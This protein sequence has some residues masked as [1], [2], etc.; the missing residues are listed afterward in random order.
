MGSMQGSSANSTRHLSTGRSAGNWAAFIIGLPLGIGILTFLQYGPVDDS[1]KRYVSHEVEWVEVVMFTCALGALLS[2]LARQPLERRAFR[3]QILP[4]WDGP[5]VPV[6]EATPLFAGLSRLPLYLQKTMV[7][8]RVRAV[9]EFLCRRGSA[10]ELDDQLRAVADNDAMAQEN[11]YS[12]IRFITW[13]IPILGFLG[14]V[15]GITKS[16]S[17]IDPDKLEHDLSSVTDGL[18]FAFD[19]TALALG[20]TMITMFCTFLV[21]RTEQGTLEAVDRYTEQHLAHRFQRIPADSGPFVEIVRQNAQILVQATE[22]LVRR[23]AELWA[24]TVEEAD[25]RRAESDKVQQGILTKGLEAALENTLQHHQKRL[26]ALEKQAEA[27]GAGMLDKLAGV[28]QAVH[29][30][31]A[32]MSR[33]A[34]S[35]AMHAETLARLQ[36]SEHHLLQLQETLNRN[37]NL[38]AGAGSFEQ[39]VHSLTAAV[40]LL[41]ARATT[42]H[43]SALPAYPVKRP[44][45][46]A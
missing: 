19:A 30:Q 11:S 31:Q 1:I 24:K 35:M 33:I 5:A 43:T 36:D 17:S 26:M 29:N 45:A 37:L 23:Q 25:M 41:T 20:L 21:E 34:E 32:A 4:A 40:H 28:A 39:A 16:I 9:L 3:G 8:G 7:A 22:T 6:S 46:A 2:K 42:P 27:Q 10:A 18:A 38:L 14:T 12:L 15:L 13:A 44:G